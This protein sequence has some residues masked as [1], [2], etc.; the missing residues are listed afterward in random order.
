MNFER[1]KSPKEAMKIGKAAFAVEIQN[2]NGS[3]GLNYPSDKNI[4]ETLKKY[5]EKIALTWSK[6]TRELFEHR[7]HFTLKNEPDIHLTLSVLADEYLE[8][9]GKFYQMPPLS[10]F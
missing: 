10:E 5:E 4:H 1:G 7:W 3:L 8:Y 9:K 6:T 2:V